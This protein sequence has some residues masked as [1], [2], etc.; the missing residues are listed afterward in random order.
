MTRWPGVLLPFTDSAWPSVPPRG[1]RSFPQ[2]LDPCCHT[3]F[4]GPQA[5]LCDR[6]RCWAPA[7]QA[8]LPNRMA[9][10][11]AFAE[12]TVY[13]QFSLQS[14]QQDVAT[15]GLQIKPS[16]RVHCSPHAGTRL[17]NGSQA[18]ALGKWRISWFLGLRGHPPGQLHGRGVGQTLEGG[19]QQGSSCSG[20]HSL[21]P[22]GSWPTAQGQVLFASTFPRARSW[23][24]LAESRAAGGSLPPWGSSRKVRGR[25][26]L[27]AGEL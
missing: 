10:H 9:V 4:S 19:G 17:P 18:P 2:H 24:L 20:S 8:D 27:L 12:W 1:R 7:W 16:C 25:W 3:S 6:H 26:A 23:L 14:P 5:L 22:T 21:P 13:I 11:Q 15:L